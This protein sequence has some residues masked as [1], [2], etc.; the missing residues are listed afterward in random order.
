MLF[1]VFL[2][3]NTCSTKSGKSLRWI[4]IFRRASALRRDGICGLATIKYHTCPPTKSYQVKSYVK[5][6]MFC[7][8][9]WQRHSF[10]FSFKKKNI[11]KTLLLSMPGFTKVANFILG[12]RFY[13]ND[14]IYPFLCV[15][16]VLDARCFACSLAILFAQA[17]MIDVIITANW[18]DKVS[19]TLKVIV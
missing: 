8:K 16:W 5:Q 9:L 12:C 6:G 17:G 3:R 1:L 7:A 14:A 18:C 2:H 4:L 15:S 13:F 19:C 11:S 10:V